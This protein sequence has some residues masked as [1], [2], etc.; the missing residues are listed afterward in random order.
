MDIFTANVLE[1]CIRPTKLSGSTNMRTFVSKTHVVVRK[2]HS[3]F[4][5]RFPN[6]FALTEVTHLI[7]SG[8]IK[9]STIVVSH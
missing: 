3:S 6:S 8:S 4:F 9:D 1:M 5:V 2:E 7:S